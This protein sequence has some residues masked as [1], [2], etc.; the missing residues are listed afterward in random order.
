VSGG[1]K[2]RIDALDAHFAKT[3]PSGGKDPVVE[4]IR[5]G[6]SFI[7]L[8]LLEGKGYTLENIAA[9]YRGITEAD[10]TLH[11]ED[12]SA[13]DAAKLVLLTSFPGSWLPQMRELAG[14]S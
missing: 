2:I 12:L 8:S 5:P 14:T 13:E 10:S 4:K 7:D 1:V 9:D 6:G 11:P 3:F